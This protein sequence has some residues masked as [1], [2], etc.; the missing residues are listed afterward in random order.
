MYIHFDSSTFEVMREAIM[1]G[2]HRI[3]STALAP[4]P[5]ARA[6]LLRVSPLIAKGRQAR[7]SWCWHRFVRFC[8]LKGDQ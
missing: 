6:A 7:S 8:D 1:K 5:G 3:D 2:A 4:T